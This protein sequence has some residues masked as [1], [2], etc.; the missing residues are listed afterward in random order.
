MEFGI[1]ID[2]AWD[3]NDGDLVL[4]KDENNVS[5]AVV[6]RLTCFQPNFTVYY[7]NYGGSLMEHLGSRKDEESLKFIQIELD[8]ILEQEERIL[9]YESNLSYTDTGV[10]IDLKLDVDGENVDLN[11]I[12]DREGVTIAD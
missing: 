9:E 10:R 4:V 5:Q 6:N 7:E 12:L 8:S 1:D 2:R 3:F 11:L